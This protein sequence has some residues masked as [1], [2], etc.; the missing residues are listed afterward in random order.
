[1]MIITSLNRDMYKVIESIGSLAKGAFTERWHLSKELE[2]VGFSQES[3]G[4]E[5][6][7]GKE[8]KYEA[9]KKGLRKHGVLWDIQIGHISR[10]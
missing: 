9:K 5:N 2:C 8:H 10:A 1:M 4:K 3:K 6:I 7:I